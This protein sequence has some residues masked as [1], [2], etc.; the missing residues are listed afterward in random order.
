[1]T[2]LTHRPEGNFSYLPGSGIY[3][4]GAVADKGYTLAH[5]TLRNP[6][7]LAAGFKAI[8]QHLDGVG[9]PMQALCGLE[10]RIAQ[11]LTFDGFGALSADYI[12]LLNKYNLR[13]GD[14]AT[15]TRTNVAIERAD[16]AP[17]APSIYGFT[18]TIPGA[19][20]G[21]RKSFIGSGIGELNGGGRKDIIQLGKTSPKAMAI[22]AKWVMDAINVQ[23]ERL[24]VKWTDVSQTTVYTV[25]TIDA[26]VE[27][28]ILG[29]MG[30]A[31][32]YGFHWMY[33]RPP[34]V[35]LEFEV[36]VR[37]ASQELFL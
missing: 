20:S 5:A 19:R 18:Y 31:A 12:K 8:Q 3:C 15:S 16:L 23:L 26:Y 36:D 34:I 9:R 10:L 28:V 6:T 11:P 13:D 27:D 32:R 14:N 30:P 2:K 35:E 4:R 33:T 21:N 29:G 37:G 25:H 17:K 7:P 1:M 22:K 24:S